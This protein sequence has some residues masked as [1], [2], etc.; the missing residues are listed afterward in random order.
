MIS[1]LQAAKLFFGLRDVQVLRQIA[2]VIRDLFQLLDCTAPV[3]LVWQDLA[4]IKQAHSHAASIASEGQELLLVLLEATVSSGG[5]RATYSF[6]GA[7]GKPTLLRSAIT[8][9]CGDEL[10]FLGT[11]NISTIKEGFS[12]HVVVNLN[13]NL[14]CDVWLQY[15]AMHLLGCPRY[16]MIFDGWV[17]LFIRVTRCY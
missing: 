16:S 3:I 1:I 12:Q 14:L 17:Q 15:F 9:I 10:L 11:T 4:H 2:Q 13:G 8:S 5:I 6:G 7:R